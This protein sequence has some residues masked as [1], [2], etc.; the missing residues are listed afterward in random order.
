MTGSKTFFRK[1]PRFSFAHEKRPR[2]A[3]ASDVLRVFLSASVALVVETLLLEEF[4]HRLADVS[5]G[6]GDG[7]ARRV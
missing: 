7:D 5:D 4:H 1:M 6:V 2:Y 3:G